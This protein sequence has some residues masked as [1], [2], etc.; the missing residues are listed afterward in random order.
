MVPPRPFPPSLGEH[1]TEHVRESIRERAVTN[2][3]ASRPMGFEPS[4]TVCIIQD[5]SKR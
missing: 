3:R 1:R 2:P 5:A 4:Y